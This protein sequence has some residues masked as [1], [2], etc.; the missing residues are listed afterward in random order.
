MMKTCR[1]TSPAPLDVR[2]KPMRFRRDRG[3]LYRESSGS[4][5]TV[6]RMLVL[7][8]NRFREPP[9]EARRLRSLRS[10]TQMSSPRVERH[11]TGARQGLGLATRKRM[12]RLA[13]RC[14]LR[15]ERRT[16]RGRSAVA[17][18]KGARG[19]SG[20]GGGRRATSG[21]GRLRKSL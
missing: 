8:A 7:D 2:L 15:A 18:G 13:P 12:L 11:V 3:P 6:G 19:K 20:H 1:Y 4:L 14:A 16:A 21:C 17:D 10:A 5:A 9:S